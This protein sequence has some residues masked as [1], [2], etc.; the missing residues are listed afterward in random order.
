[1]IAV[2][3][4]KSAVIVVRQ[5]VVVVAV[6]VA[7]T[8][9]GEIVV[10]GTIKTRA[11]APTAAKNKHWRYNAKGMVG[12]LCQPS[13]FFVTK[14]KSDRDLSQGIGRAI[15]S[16]LHGRRFIIADNHFFGRVPFDLPTQARGQVA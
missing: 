11:K 10:D 3:A 13:P 8:P 2:I 12:K 4:S 9:A 6:A 7:A 1:M 14:A 16:A 5:T 15:R